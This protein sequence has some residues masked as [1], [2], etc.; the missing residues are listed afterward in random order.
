MIQIIH[1]KKP[2]LKKVKFS[3]DS[4]LSDKLDDFELT[5]YL[6]KSHFLCF[7]GRGG[8]GKTSLAVN[9][10]RNKELFYRC[11]NQIFLISPST[12][13]QSIENNFF[14]KKINPND[15]FDELTI[16]TLENINEMT[17]ENSDQGKTSLI[18]IDDQQ[19]AL[20]EPAISKLLLQMNNNK[21]HQKLYIWILNQ[22]YISIP[23]QIRQNITDFF[24]F[25]LNKVEMNNIINEH[26]ELS[27]KKIEQVLENC[28][29]EPYSFMYLN[30]NNQKIFSNWDEIVIN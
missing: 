10:L 13:R 24:I 21:R 19:K 9:L 29:Q 17:K 23:K 7:L 28:F 12:S 22:N 6:N 11:F 27:E 2:N 20:K 1:N 30:S 5:K 16:E 18:I 25:K 15:I 4:K 3:C 8:S 26:I 14:D